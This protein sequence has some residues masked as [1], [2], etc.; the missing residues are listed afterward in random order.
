MKKNKKLTAI[1]IFFLLVQ[2]GFLHASA[3]STWTDCYNG[4]IQQ[5][6][7]PAVCI[8]GCAYLRA[9]N[10]SSGTGTASGGSNAAASSGGTYTDCYRNCLA[11]KNDSATCVSGCAYLRASNASSGTGSTSGASNTGNTGSVTCDGTGATAFQ[12]CSLGGGKT[13]QCSIGGT[14]VDTS[15]GASSAGSSSSSSSGSES[16]AAG[17]VSGTPRSAYSGTN[18]TSMSASCSEAGFESV[19]GICFPTSGQ[20]GLSDASV[21]KILTN[22]FS[23]IMGLFSVLCIMAFVFSGIQYLTATGDTKSIETA[24]NNAKWSSVGVLVGLSGFVIVKAIA[25]AL[26]GNPYF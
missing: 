7:S 2:F 25:A 10:A 14:C 13:G 23:W 11:E 26:Q 4:C 5:G 1:G 15:G 19:G 12:T 22:L 16:S 3:Q 21:S 6:E 8:D 18:T 9:S 24:K 17:S 20:T